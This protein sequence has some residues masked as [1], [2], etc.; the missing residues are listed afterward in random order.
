TYNHTQV[1]NRLVTEQD[2]GVYGLFRKE[3]L[4]DIT[5]NFILYDGGIK[6]VMRYQQYSAIKKIQKRIGHLIPTKHG[7]KR[8]GGILWQT[9]GSGKS[10]TMVMFVKAL[11]EDP[12]ISNPRV[13]IVT[14][15]R[16]LDR[17]IRDTFMDAGLK[18]EVVQ[19]KSGNHLIELIKNKDLR[20]ITTLVHKFQS[21]SK[22]H[23]G[24]V[25]NDKNIFV[26]IDE[27]H[28][29]QGGEANLEMNRIIPNACYIAFTGTPLLKDQK[30]QNKFGRFIDKY[31]IDDALA[32]GIILP[33]IYEGRYIDLRQDKKEID[34]QF[35]R[36]TEGMV[37]RDKAKLQYYVKTQ[38]IKDNPS[39]IKEIA[40]DIERHYL[41]QFA[42][43]GLK[44]Q[45]VAPSKY[46]AVLFQK[47]FK[48]SGK[49]NTTLVISDENGI[50]AKEDDRKKEVEEYL[51]D[52]KED[53]QSLLS[54]E[55]DVVKS[56]KYNE[57]GVEILIVVDKLLTGFDAPRNTVL[58][59]A[60]ELKDHNLL[61]AIARVNRLYD[62]DKLPKTAGYIIDYS[63]NAL[64]IKTAMELFGNYDKE[65]VRG[66]LIDVHEKIE[67]LESAYSNLHDHFKGVGNNNDDEAYL[68]YLKD[69]PTRKQFYK[70]LNSF[71][72]V[73]TEC[74]TLQEFVSEFE[75]LDVYRKELKK[76]MNLRR[77]ADV[78]FADKDDLTKYKIALIKIMD[79]NI[80][81]EEAELLTK[82]V[83]ISN[84][85]AF[86]EIV[87]N[88][89]SAKSK[90]EAITSQVKK[91]ISEKMSQ[92]P[93]F[94]ERF[95]LRI[96]KL[97]DDMR[98]KKLADIEALKQ[99]KLIQDEVL[100][101]KDDSLPQQIK[102]HKGSDIFYRNLQSYLNNRG[103]N[104][105]DLVKIILE[106]YSLLKTE[107]VV[108]WHIN[109]EKQRVIK[110]KID[111]FLYDDVK[112]KGGID[113]SAKDIETI[114]D[115]VLELALA[116]H[117]LLNDAK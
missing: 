34:K 43:T 56:F 8:E 59:L 22:K 14:D 88:L 32:D 102:N 93:E 37:V 23:S 26:L 4:L 61:Q 6:K 52:I 46:S 36:I 67:E 48:S 111:N 107:F 10:L 105:A 41:K 83:S 28:R 64:N 15:R 69:E 72:K 39:R 82:Q 65:D 17:Q 113:L 91:V 94:Y 110:N 3:R 86:E 55:K 92:D 33:L 40:Y 9:Q 101:K 27:A 77:S 66:A 13:L 99:A 73:F 117:E 108:D 84:Q 18:K 100:N 89:G 62:N 11:I 12:N 90:A 42:G 31:T 30:S 51:K 97:L 19:A 57:A 47:Y 79:E 81:A 116:N 45:I 106:L 78:R 7:E 49:L 21:A 1:L 58:Y 50:I 103:V 25:D 60:K 2:K 95:S 109:T 70:H 29:T 75:H 44:A 35:N 98:A 20:V 76:F 85:E 53:Y 5:K 96:K 68:Q 24:F 38:S 16:D 104:D 71:L 80:K 112:I 74:N 87:E 54:Y 115:K 114:V 63:E